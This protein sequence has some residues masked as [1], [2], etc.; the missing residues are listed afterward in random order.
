MPLMDIKK[1]EKH[2]SCEVED[3]AETHICKLCVILQSRVLRV[4]CPH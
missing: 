2:S 4:V 1:I 3:F